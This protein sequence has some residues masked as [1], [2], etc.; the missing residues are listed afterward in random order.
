M[1]MSRKGGAKRVRQKRIINDRREKRSTNYVYA[2]KHGERC[3]G[4]RENKRWVN[5]NKA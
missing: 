1:L 3:E 5:R 4:Q 2:G